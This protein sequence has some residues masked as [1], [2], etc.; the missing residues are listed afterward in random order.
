MKIDQGIFLLTPN[1][2]SFISISQISGG[3]KRPL[4]FTCA[5]LIVGHILYALAYTAN[6][7]YLILI[8][9]MVNGLGLTMWMYSKR[10][11]SSHLV[12]V[13]RR[14][15]L[16]GWLVVGQATGMSVGP[17]LGGAF[18]KIG[19]SNAVFNGFTSPAWIMAVVWLAFWVAVATLYEEEPPPQTSAQPLPAAPSDVESP[20]GIL[21]PEEP[22][23]KTSHTD[24]LHQLPSEPI[25][26][27]LASHAFR[28]SAMH[29]GVIVCMCWYAM[30]C[31]F[32]L[33]AWESNIPVFGASSQTT[34]HWSP[35][36][37][38]NFIAIG[39]VVTFP[40]LFLNLRYARRTQ[41]RYILVAGSGIGLAGLL[42]VL[43][44]LSTHT[45]NW[46]SFFVTWC[47]VALGFN[48]ASTVT[49][50]LLSKQLPGSWNGRISIAIQYSNYLGRVTGAVWG[51]SGV[52][53]GMMEYVGF[54]VAL[55]GVGVLM[56]LVLWRNLKAKTG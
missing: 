33:G 30:T 13:R 12:G 50:S 21:T 25:P 15:M 1:H 42:I 18:Y 56:S 31:F 11:C 2:I 27:T 9:R 47:M 51:G 43:S 48:L 38:G 14:T 23:S 55:T 37:A 40:F 20:L 19:F 36:A 7:L 35:F 49:L 34:F 44:L 53:V 8:G 17:F 16:A 26:A 41:D 46:G 29:L 45:I 28:P 52:K 3:Y 6:F 4:H 24:A 5:A 54:E 22:G 10:Y 39:G 32:I